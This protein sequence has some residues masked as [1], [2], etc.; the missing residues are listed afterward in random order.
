MEYILIIALAFWVYRLSDRISKLEKHSGHTSIA[1]P[2]PQTQEQ[3][4]PVTA[5]PIPIESLTHNPIPAASTPPTQAPQYVP[6]EVRVLRS[7]FTWCSEDWLMKLGGLLVLLGM[8]WFVSYAFAN[9]WIGS[10]GRITLG[11]VVGALVLALGRY[12]MQRFVAQGS[13]VMV[14]GATILTATLFAARVVYDFFTPASVLVALFLVASLLA[15]TAVQ[16]NRRSLAYANVLLAG[17]APLLVAS[18]E[19]SI[20]ALFAYLLVFCASTLLVVAR[21]GWRDLVLV[22]LGVVAVHSA[23]VLTLGASDV[24]TTGLMFAYVFTATFFMSTVLGM[25]RHQKKRSIDLVTA[26]GTG[27]FLLGWILAAAP[28]HWQSVLCLGWALVFAVG[29]FL[30]FRRTNIPEYFYVYGAVASIL[31]VV[32]TTIEFDGAVQT[33]VFTAE[34]FAATVL[35]YMITRKVSALP[36]LSLS[37]VIPIF[38]SLAHVDSSAWNTGIMHADAAALLIVTLSIAGLSF[39][40][41][42]V[43]LSLKDAAH[44][45]TLFLLQQAAWSVF[46]VYSVAL[47]WLVSHALFMGDVGTSVALVIYAITGGAFYMYGR[48]SSKEWA[49]IVAGILVALVMGRLLLVDV[50]DMAL[51]GRVITFLLIGVLLMSV[52]WLERSVFT[53]KTT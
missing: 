49:I 4:V 30:V 32:A 11:L 31:I 15:F 48:S 5:P 34:A 7:F 10:V 20:E 24:L 19:P 29:A 40:F 6:G 45:H 12:R 22:G 52:A 25:I 2:Q 23:A 35:G 14:V 39:F 50:W 27:L 44:V 1:Q 41:L 18:K 21:T 53:K 37:F 33:I 51:L 28:A 38:L 9:N 46:G 43:Q 26:L 3:T 13:I 17:I 8:G 47:V 16:Q 42:W 36:L